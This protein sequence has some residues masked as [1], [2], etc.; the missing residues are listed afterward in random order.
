MSLC[1]SFRHKTLARQVQ[2]AVDLR[3]WTSWVS[4]RGSEKTHVETEDRAGGL[5]L[6][7]QLLQ[8]LVEQFKEWQVQQT[9]PGLL[10][11]KRSCV[12]SRRERHYKGV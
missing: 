2:S 6:W 4:P 3:E 9:D 11:L 10:V 1:G 8:V 7:R 12:Y 5:L